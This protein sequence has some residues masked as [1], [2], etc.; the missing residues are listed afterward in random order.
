MVPVEV[1]QDDMVGF[2]SGLPFPLGDFAGKRFFTDKVLFGEVWLADCSPREMRWAGHVKDGKLYLD[3]SAHGKFVH[4]RKH[5]FKTPTMM[6]AGAYRVWL[7]A[8]SRPR[9]SNDEQAQVFTNDPIDG[10]GGPWVAPPLPALKYWQRVDIA[11]QKR[12]AP[13]RIR[14]R[15][16]RFHW[17]YRLNALVDVLDELALSHQELTVKAEETRMW[18]DYL[19][20]FLNVLLYSRTNQS[21]I[22]TNPCK[23]AF[24]GMKGIA[25]AVSNRCRNFINY[26]TV[27]GEDQ[28]LLSP[29]KHI[30][31][32][33][34]LLWKLIH[35][36]AFAQEV[37][38]FDPILAEEHRLLL[39]RLQQVFN[40][41]PL[42]IDGV[43]DV[44]ERRA[45]PAG[46][47]F[48]YGREFARE[49][50]VPYFHAKLAKA[51][52]VAFKFDK[53]ESRTKWL[54]SA[55]RYGIS[56]LNAAS[57][58]IVR[59]DV[60]PEK[61][62]A[63]LKEEA[64][65][66]GV[67]AESSTMMKAANELLEKCRELGKA[68]LANGWVAKAHRMEAHGGRFALERERYLKELAADGTELAKVR[69]EIEAV[70]A[71]IA[72]TPAKVLD[73]AKKVQFADAPLRPSLVLG[74]QMFEIGVK[75]MVARAAWDAF[76]E[77]SGLDAVKKGAE[78]GVKSID[79]LGTSFGFLGLHKVLEF[80][81]GR[82]GV[83]A[84]RIAMR[85]DRLG[86]LSKGLGAAADVGS[87]VMYTI[88]ISSDAHNRELAERFLAEDADTIR[89]WQGVNWL[90]KAMVGAASTATTVTKAPVWVKLQAAGY[91]VQFIGE[92]G[93]KL[94]RLGAT[95]HRHAHDVDLRIRA[96]AAEADQLIRER[97]GDI[98]L[99][100]PA[101]QAMMARH[102]KAFEW[103]LPIELAL[104]RAHFPSASKEGAAAVDPEGADEH[105]ESVSDPLHGA[106]PFLWPG[107]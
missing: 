104:Y 32:V 40:N 45:A 19:R 81:F 86:R 54:N 24:I 23:N 43:V 39:G 29:R 106:D 8:W 105:Q 79:F 41:V 7:D 93:E 46:T 4:N 50:T 30:N 17:L 63:L 34:H 71:Q 38:L 72:G 48:A 89:T 21:R 94:A 28:S 51:D 65:L 6:Q 70:R 27:D 52:G 33:A 57:I 78:F 47:S 85:L 98:A 83:T 67:A 58:F 42:I 73:K 80:E 69:E 13:C 90:G 100:Q 55:R 36:D 18:A 74:V 31:N 84:E 14:M 99:Y 95:E 9:P 76:Q 35:N 77:T 53:P 37:S 91:L 5:S 96:S 103:K 60:K 49:F 26:G 59:E 87:A 75:W 16:H 15:S 56:M 107:T 101:E 92:F 44:D 66:W 64:R 68:A 2:E 22:A 12:G 20:E 1:V 97:I 82:R 3:Q 102:M 61:L 88:Q 25:E 62:I 10:D 11:P